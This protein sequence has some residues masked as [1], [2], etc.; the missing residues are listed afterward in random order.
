MAEPSAP[1]LAGAGLAA[2]LIAVFGPAAGEYAAIVFAALG[3]ALWPL[4]QR[5]EI[6]RL[7]GA[8][9]VLRLV[10][11]AASLTGLAAWWI[12]R[13]WGVPA[14]TATAPIAFGIAALGDRWTAL[15]DAVGERLRRVIGGGKTDGGQT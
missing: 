10:I 13:H 11:T 5:G 6:S 9:L 2:A 1:S 8:L 14:A 7:Q 4:A 12:E 3:G 15:L